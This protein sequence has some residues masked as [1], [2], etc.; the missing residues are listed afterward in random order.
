[1]QMNAHQH[2]K[3][4]WCSIG[5]NAIEIGLKAA[6]DGVVLGI[7]QFQI[8]GPLLHAQH[9]LAADGFHSFVGQGF[10]AGKIRVTCQA[11]VKMLPC[12]PFRVSFTN[13]LASKVPG[14]QNQNQDELQECDLVD[15]GS[16][17]L[18]GD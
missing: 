7:V 17:D 4:Y 15:S 12:K 6:N 18:A 1:M 13:I 10:K 2:L 16:W 3:Y 8:V 14:V 9:F 5:L 11:R